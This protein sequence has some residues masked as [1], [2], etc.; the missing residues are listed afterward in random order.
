MGIFKSLFGREAEQPEEAQDKN[1]ER[2]FDILKYDGLKAMKIGKTGY[3]IRC[4]NEALAIREEFETLNY[5]ALVYIQENDTT[6]A[7]DIYTRMVK[8][9]PEHTDT[10]LNRAQLYLREQQPEAVIADC[11]YVLSKNPAEFRAYF[12]M[13]KA[14]QMMQQQ[15]EAIDDLNKAAGIKSDFMELFLLRSSIWMELKEYEN[16]LND[17]NTAISISSEEESTYLQRA[18]IYEALGNTEAAL[19]DYATAV[20]LNPFH[21]QAYLETGRILLDRHLIDETIRHFD[22]AIENKPDFGR[23]YTARGR[24]K[25]LKGDMEGAQEDLQ[26]GAELSEE[27]DEIEKQPVNFNDMYANRPL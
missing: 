4:F 5:L 7:I 12:F 8:I 10:F 23:A 24:A 2:N 16:A 6:E 18:A 1:Q 13:A 27:N 11:E 14:R 20:E 3:A 25:E 15:Q 19:Q 22:E 9:D 17:T 26:T 21:E